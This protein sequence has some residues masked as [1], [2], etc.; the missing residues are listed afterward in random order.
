MTNIE[1]DWFLVGHRL[2]EV[3][4]HAVVPWDSPSTVQLHPKYEGEGEQTYSVAVE[5]AASRIATTTTPVTLSPG[6]PIDLDIDPAGLLEPGMI[7][8]GNLVLSDIHGEEL[9]IPLLLEAESPYT[10]DGWLAWLAKPSNGL[11]VIC[12]LLAIS[13]ITGGRSREPVPTN[14]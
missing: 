9:R 6:N 13:V 7:A 11:F 2:S 5:G 14:D 1:L 4:L 12:F 8:R 3:E 10:G